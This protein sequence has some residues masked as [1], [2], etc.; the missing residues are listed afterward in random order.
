MTSASLAQGEESRQLARAAHRQGEEVK[1]ISSWAAILFAPGLIAGVYGMNFDHMPELHWRYGYPIAI[2]AMLVLAGVLWLVCPEAQLALTRVRSAHGLVVTRVSSVRCR[3]EDQTTP[4]HGRP[5]RRCAGTRR[6]RPV[7]RARHR[8]TRC[9]RLRLRRHRHRHLRGHPVL[10][11]PVVHRLRGGDDP[12]GPAAVARPAGRLP[13][14]GDRVV[15][16]RARSRPGRSHLRR[17]WLGNRGHY[18]GIDRAVRPALY[19]QAVGTTTT[20]T[21]SDLR[22]TDASGTAVT[23]WSLVGA[24]AEETAGG[25]SI[26]WTADTPFS[27]LTARPGAADELAP[28]ARAGTPGSAPRP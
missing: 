17:V 23:G 4:R 1:K 6:D 3:R 27:S 12:G 22:V 10:A 7:R 8:G 2:L 25:E 11:G 21:L 24:D 20:A 16:G 14:P 13:A 19:Q 18:T 9:A 28:P 5:A 15:D 26:T